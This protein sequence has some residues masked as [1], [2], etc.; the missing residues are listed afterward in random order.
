MSWLLSSFYVRCARSQGGQNKMLRT[1]DSIGL[2]RDDHNNNTNK[3]LPKTATTTTTS[4]SSTTRVHHDHHYLHDHHQQHQQHGSQRRYGF[5]ERL[6]LG[7]PP[8][9]LRPVPTLKD[10]CSCK[11]AGSALLLC[12]RSLDL[13]RRRCSYFEAFFIWIPDSTGPEPQSRRKSTTSS[14]SEGFI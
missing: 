7:V 5:L 10:P 12:G 14:P 1:H 13:C 6:R 11:G 8:R 3:I 9:L 2:H 4:S